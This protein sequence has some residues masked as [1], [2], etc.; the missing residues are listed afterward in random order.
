M[1]REEGSEVRDHSDDRGRDAGEG[2][3]EVVVV[4]QPLDVRR[5]EKDEQEAG[6]EGHPRHQQ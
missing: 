1:Q 4:A 5:A 6:H 3:G 2:C